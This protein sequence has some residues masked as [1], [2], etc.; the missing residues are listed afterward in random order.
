MQ[1]AIIPDCETTGK[2]SYNAHVIELGA[3][4][5]DS[6]LKEVD[7]FN[8]LSNPGEEALRYAAPEA[9]QKNGISLEEIRTG[10]PIDEAAA[11]FQVFLAKYSNAKL[12]AFNNG[13]DLWFLAR[14]PWLVPAKSWGE[15]IMLASMDMMRDSGDLETF[16]DGTAKW[17]TLEHAARFFGV[18]YEKGHRALPDARVA[19]GVFSEIQR[20][21]KSQ[22]DVTLSEARNMME[23]GM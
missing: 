19:A 3:V 8:I 23:D 5:L 20:R 22:E 7:H 11:R 6:M 15:C 17:P 1:Y 12:H 9:L 16:E 14:K 13:F 4:V 2:R 10:V 18:L 21:R